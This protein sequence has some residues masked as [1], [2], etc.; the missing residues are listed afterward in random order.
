MI[1]NIIFDFGDVFINLNK[2]G[3]VDAFTKMGLQSWNQTMTEINELF[4]V[5]AVSEKTFLEVFQSQIPNHS[6]EEI[7]AGWNTILGEFPQYRL[8]F[9]QTLKGKYHLFLLSNTDAIHI[10]HFRKTVGENFY[11]SFYQSFEKVYFSFEINLRKPNLS[12]YEFIINDAEINPNE[13][14]FVDDKL[15]NIEG[16]KKAGL[17]TWHLEVGQEDVIELLQQPVFKP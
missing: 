12:C 4:E 2:Q 6:L 1:K 15:E 17:Q 7:K 5:G 13:S 16:A 3:P 8:D 10:A 14:L 11:Q 9:L